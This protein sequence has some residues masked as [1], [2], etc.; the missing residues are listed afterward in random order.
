MGLKGRKTGY[1]V[2]FYVPIVPYITHLY[3][4]E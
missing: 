2:S 1:L 3:S 4:I